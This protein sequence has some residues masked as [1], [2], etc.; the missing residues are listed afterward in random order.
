[1]L[2][3]AKHFS[4]CIGEAVLITYGSYASPTESLVKT[5]SIIAFFDTSVA[6]LAGLIVFPALAS[7]NKP[8]E[9][10]G[11]IYE[12]MPTIFDAMSMAQFKGSFSCC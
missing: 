10:L 7:F 3:F 5:A 8:R 2:A 1:M 4:L 12:V 9:D 6:I 11:L